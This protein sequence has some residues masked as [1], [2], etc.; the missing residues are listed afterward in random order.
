M[1]S[2]NQRLEAMEPSVNPQRPTLVD[3]PPDE[4][5]AAYFRVDKKLFEKLNKLSEKIL[6]YCQSERM[7][8]INSPPYIIDILPDICQVLNVIHATYESKF[9]VLENI[10]Y[11]CVMSRNLLEKLQGIIE[12]F[13]MA[14]KR[15]YDERSEERAKLTKFT[16]LLSHM[17]AEMKSLFPKDVYEGQSFRVAKQDAAEFW[18]CNF[19]EKTVVAWPEF[20]RKLN[21]VHKIANPT[22][23]VK[24]R[25]TVQLSE[26]RY[27]SIFEF[28]IFTRLFQPW[29]NLLNNWKFLATE[30][31]VGFVFYFINKSVFMFF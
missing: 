20:E 25:E 10:E 5:P 12:L 1:N 6:K 22:E 31:P 7:Q 21:R 27:V 26:S 30:H 14:G 11:F 28:D 9:H 3:H 8:L 15:I 17:L 19:R 16:L 4:I 18:R 13:K 23:A 29:N 2:S 24:L